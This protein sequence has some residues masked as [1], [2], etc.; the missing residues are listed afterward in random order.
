VD[1]DVTRPLVIVGVDGSP[2]SLQALRRAAVEARRAGAVLKVTYAYTV[3]TSALAAQ[4]LDSRD[5]LEQAAQELIDVCLDEALGGL[6]ADVPVCR[7]VVENCPPGPALVGRVR[8]QD[9]LIV[10]GAS[11]SGL[12]RLWRRPVAAH[13]VRHATCPV[14]VV[15]VP[16]L[17]R[18]F[19]TRIR[20]RHLDR[21]L[22]E[23]CQGIDPTPR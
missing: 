5:V 2:T 12:A 15:P 4:A 23:L 14:L 20:R 21:Q 1:G 9:D 16:T 6:P 13:C 11:R 3:P 7:T 17:L 18:E 10:V 22:A 8:S 19:R